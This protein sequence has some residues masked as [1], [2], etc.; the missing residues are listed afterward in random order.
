[1]EEVKH[2]GIHAELFHLYKVHICVQ[3]IYSDRIRILNTMR[4][5][6]DWKKTG[7]KTQEVLPG[8]WYIL[9]LHLG[10]GHSLLTL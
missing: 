10:A 6:G 7:E 1:M 3:I 8:Y 5:C 4:Q 9:C 2:N